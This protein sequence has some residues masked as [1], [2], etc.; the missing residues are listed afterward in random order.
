MRLILLFLDGVGI[1]KDDASVN[2]FFKAHLPVLYSTLGNRLP[3]RKNKR[4]ETTEAGC[5]PLNA[6]LG[7]AGMP[8]SGTG[9]VALF[10]GKN[11]AKLAGRH[12]GPYPPTTLRSTLEEYNLFTQVRRKG[13]SISFLN[14]YPHQFFDYV[15]S[16]TRRLTVTTLSCFY[17]GIPLHGITELRKNEALS[18]DITRKRW[19]ELGYPDL[20]LLPEHE[21]GMH[22]WRLAQLHDV[23]VFEY[24][25]PDHAGHSQ[26]MQFAVEVLETFDRF[27]GGILSDFDFRNSLLIIVSDHGNIEDLSIKSH[28]RNQVPCIVIGH[29][30]K[31]FTATVRNLTHITPT[32]LKF[33]T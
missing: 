6:T 10:T 8:Q 15:K 21:A 28:T 33:L 5:T 12:F 30:H 27:L 4:I 22:L 29:E 7:V 23:T 32:I 1:G 16:G 18:A 20:L 26:N 14:A 13:K 31:R 2:P 9:Q 3:S 17:A 11:G 24:W 25:L 19:P